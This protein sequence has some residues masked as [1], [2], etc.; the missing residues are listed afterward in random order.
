MNSKLFTFAAMLVAL[1]AFPAGAALAA[2][3]H[4][5]HHPADSTAPPPAD[6]M[7]NM[8]KMREQMAAIRATRD[9]TER[10]RLMD[11]HMQT[12][13]SMMQQMRGHNGCM[14]MGNGMQMK[15]GQ[16]GGGMNMMQ[17]M[18]EQMQQHQEAMRGAGK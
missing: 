10:A 16:A 9:S 17:M 15:E 6:A 2:D 14:M 7:S 18:M 5:A 8:Q 3:E 13:Q 1:L 4:A 11:E 12:M